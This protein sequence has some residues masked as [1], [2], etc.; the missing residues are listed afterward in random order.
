M[1]PL[2]HRT[3]HAMSRVGQ[4]RTTPEDRVAAVLRELGV[5][6]RRNVKT[7]PGSP[8]FANQARGWVIQVHGCFWH[9]HDCKRATVPAHNHQ[10]WMAKFARNKARDAAAEA[11]IRSRGLRVLTVWECETKDTVGLKNRLTSYLR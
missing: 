6:Y 7:L 1:K 9:Q 4:K 3:S 5:R 11:A 8:D 2:N 10:A